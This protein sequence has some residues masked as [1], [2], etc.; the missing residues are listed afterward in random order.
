M[1]HSRCRRRRFLGA[2]LVVGV[3]SH[4]TSLRSPFASLSNKGRKVV[5]T[6]SMRRPV[7]VK[8]ILLFFR[9]TR[10]FSRRV[11]TVAILPCALSRSDLWSLGASWA[12][13][14]QPV[15]LPDYRPRFHPQDESWA[16]RLTQSPEL[17][18]GHLFF[19]SL[20]DFDFMPPSASLPGGGCAVV[21]RL[22]RSP[23]GGAAIPTAFWR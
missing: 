20:E 16:R 3:Q 17:G 19:P 21:R 6:P 11:D 22:L 15:L 7:G 4:S 14:L 18:F 2:W 13:S 12:F 8:S 10:F 5:I 23:T 1:R 9:G